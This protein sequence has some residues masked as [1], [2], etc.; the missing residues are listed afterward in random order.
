MAQQVRQA[1]AQSRQILFAELCL[2]EAAVHLERP[3]RCHEHHRRRGEPRRSA[4]DVEEFLGTE[5]SAEARLGD[6]VVAELH[7]K[8][9]RRDGVAAVSDI[10]KR[11]AVDKGRCAFEGL[12][13]VRLEGVLEQ[14]RHCALSLE[15]GAGNGLVVKGVA[16]DYAGEPLLEVG[17]GF[18][19]AE[20]RHYLA[21]D[22][23][24]KAVLTGHAVRNAAETVRDEAELAV[25]HVNAALPR[26]AAHVDIQLVALLDVIVEHCGEQVVCGA[27]GVEVA[28]EVEVDILHGHYLGVAAA[29]SAALDAEYRAERRLTQGDHNIFAYTAHTVGEA[30]GRGGLALASGGGGYGGDEYQLAVRVLVLFHQRE[31]YLCLVF[32]VLLDVFVVDARSCGYLGYRLHF[33]ALSYLD[34]G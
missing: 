22:G 18:R 2:G 3:D 33:A 6:S 25:V 34:I 21:C 8:L 19:E 5:V 16:D 11:S 7:C 20:H 30:D 15:I 29:R 32:A 1:V 17:Y 31:V 24:V 27:Y 13:Q 14:S 9:G 23:D 4:L 10:R 26:D 12:H 28:C